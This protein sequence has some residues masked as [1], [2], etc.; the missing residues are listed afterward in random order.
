[1][2]IIVHCNVLGGAL[3]LALILTQPHTCT[4]PQSL[5][6]GPRATPSP[7]PS[8]GP[9]RSPALALALVLVMGGLPRVRDTLDAPMEAITEELPE[10]SPGMGTG[11]MR[12]DTGTD[13]YGYR[14]GYGHRCSRYRHEGAQG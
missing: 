7:G 8:P 5:H 10:G 11:M 9:E 13:A 6:P 12:M 2:A 1:M 14:D 4:Q 3:A